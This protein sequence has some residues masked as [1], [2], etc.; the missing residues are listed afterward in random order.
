MKSKYE[1]DLLVTVARMYYVEGLKQEQIA[2]KVNVSRSL[3]SLILT[4][5]KELGVVDITIHDPRGNNEELTEDFKTR[6]KLEKVFVVPTSIQEQDFRLGLAVRRGIEIF[7]SVI[8]EGNTIGISWGRT[9]YRFMSEYS[10]KT[11]FE[12]LKIFPL[13]GSSDRSLKRYQM[14]EVVRQFSEKVYG[15]AKFIHAPIFP[16]SK[17]DRDLY[18]SSSALQSIAELWRNIDVAVFSIG[19]PPQQYRDIISESIERGDHFTEKV[20]ELA[21]GDIC[22]RFFDARGQFIQDEIADLTIAVPVDS[23]SRAKTK[24]CIVSGDHKISSIIGGLFSGLVDILVIDETTA[25]KVLHRMA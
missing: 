7:N 11:I 18:M 14:N 5:A 19:A 24:L 17:E 1:I 13:V 25:R 22:A 2:K 23:L 21:V 3:I 6:F 16:V 10:S 8:K 9:I 4:E 12:G 15:T 20:A